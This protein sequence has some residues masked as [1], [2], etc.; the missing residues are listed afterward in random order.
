MDRTPIVLGVDHRHGGACKPRQIPPTA[1]L[2]Q[3]LV[4]LEIVLEGHGVGDLPALD[5]AE[6]GVVDAAMH[7]QKEMLRQQEGADQAGGFVVDQQRAEE[8]LFG[9]KVAGR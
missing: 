4:P 7:R 3:R 9:L 6:D 2:L 8:R 1:S 5:H